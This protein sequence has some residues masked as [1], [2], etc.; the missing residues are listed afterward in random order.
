[1]WNS[2]TGFYRLDRAAAILDQSGR[3]PVSVDLR[4]DSV[5]VK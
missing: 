3:Y 4:D 2:M 5:L 1:M